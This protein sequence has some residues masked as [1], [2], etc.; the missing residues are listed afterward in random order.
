MSKQEEVFRK[1]SESVHISEI[2]AG[3]RVE[4]RFRGRVVASREGSGLLKRGE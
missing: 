1:V 2:P 3:G 4:I